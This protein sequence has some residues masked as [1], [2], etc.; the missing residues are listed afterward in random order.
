MRYL[1][2]FIF[3]GLSCGVFS[4][5]PADAALC[6]YQWY[7]QAIRGSNPAIHTAIVRQGPKGEV[8]L[9]HQ[10]YFQHLDSIDCVSDSFKHAEVLRFQSCQDFF[11]EVPYSVYYDQIDNDAYTFDAPCPFFTQFYWISDI[12]YWE[13]VEVLENTIDGANARVLLGLRSGKY[14]QKREVFLQLEAE[15]WRI[16]KIL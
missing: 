16:V 6:F 12:A 1:L 3:L 15:K 10:L 9:D 5:S 7:L 11:K 14:Q 13:S 4:Q 2:V 8:L